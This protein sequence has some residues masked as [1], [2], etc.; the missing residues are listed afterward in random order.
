MN[1]IF[2]CFYQLLDI[3]KALKRMMNYA[4]SHNRPQ[5]IHSLNYSFE[6]RSADFNKREKRGY[7][8][9][10]IGLRIV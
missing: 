1:G 4:A 7:T 9:Y 6:Q 3:S 8:F 2:N 10:A 5:L